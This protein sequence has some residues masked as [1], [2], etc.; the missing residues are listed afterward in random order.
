MVTKERAGGFY[1]L[2]AYYM[3]KFV[4][5]IPLVLI[6]PSFY[7]IVTFWCTGIGGPVAFFGVW[8]V[9]IVDCLAG[10]VQLYD[11]MLGGLSSLSS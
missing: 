8:A 11:Y 9:L 6:Y 3:A 4:S 7:L 10:Q 1:H 2:S 5:E